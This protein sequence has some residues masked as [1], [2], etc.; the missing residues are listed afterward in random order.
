MQAKVVSKRFNG[1][2]VIISESANT[3]KV[4][5]GKKII[6]LPKRE[7]SLILKECV[8]NGSSLLGKPWKRIKRRD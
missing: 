7:V 4:D 6:S 8:V 1:C 2:C 5:V 3:I